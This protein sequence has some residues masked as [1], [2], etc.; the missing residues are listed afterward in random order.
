MTKSTASGQCFIRRSW[1]EVQCSGLKLF[2]E[3]VGHGACAKR[4]RFN[5][6][7][8]ADRCDPTANFLNQR[9]RLALLSDIDMDFERPLRQQLVYAFAAQDVDELQA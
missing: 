9:F 6:R 4:Q 7:L 3:P 8:I 2:G 1:S 5:A